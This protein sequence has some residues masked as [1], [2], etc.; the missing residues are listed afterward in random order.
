M[1]VLAVHVQHHLR[2]EE[3]EQDARQA[4]EYCRNRGLAFRRVDVD[5]RSLAEGEGLSLEEAAR[6]LRYGA[7]EKVRQEIGAAAIFLAHHQDDQAETVLL[8]LV[9]GA[10]PGDAGNAAGKRI[11]GPSLSGNH[12]AGY[13]SLL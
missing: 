12:P 10:V 11:S 4:E 5:V 3:A 7:L 1:D 6:K 13:G 2:G 9:R 8:N